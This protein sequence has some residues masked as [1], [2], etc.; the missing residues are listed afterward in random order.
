MSVTGGAEALAKEFDKVV[1][2]TGAETTLLVLDEI[3]SVMERAEADV[4]SAADEEQVAQAIALAMDTVRASDYEGKLAQCHR[5][6]QA[7]HSKYCKF[8][9]KV[10]RLAPTARA[11][12]GVSRHAPRVHPPPPARARADAAR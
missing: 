2:Q 9:N 4:A 7:A 6:A 1:E 3:V 11:S 5:E 12:L 8:I 10:C